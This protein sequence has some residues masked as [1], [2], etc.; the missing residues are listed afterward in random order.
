MDKWINNLLNIYHSIGSGS[1]LRVVQEIQNLLAEIRSSSQK[2]DDWNKNYHKNFILFL[3]SYN[4]TVNIVSEVF[5]H[6]KSESDIW[7]TLSSNEPII[8]LETNQ[9]SSLTNVNEFYTPTS[10]KLLFSSS[11]FDIKN[12]Q[13]VLF[14]LNNYCDYML[15]YKDKSKKSK[16]ALNLIKDIV[17]QLKGINE[18]SELIK[19]NQ[20]A[21]SSLETELEEKGKNLVITERNLKR[22]V[23]EIHNL[24]EISN[25]LYAILNLKQLIN[26]ALLIIV[27]QV[28][29]QKAFAFL[30]DTNN[31]KY[32]NRFTKGIDQVELSDLEIAV[33]HPL[34]SYF[35]NRPK[36]VLVEDLI[37]DTS[38]KP[39]F[40]SLFENQIEI[41]API[42]YGDR[43]Q[44]IVGCGTLLSDQKFSSNEM[45]I[46]NILINIISISVSNAQTYEDVKNLSLTDSMTNLNNYRHFEERLKEEITR[47]I[48]NK[49]TVSLL[50]LDLDHFKNYN[51]TLGHQ[52]GDEALRNVG[53]ILK[54]AV[55]EE[56]IVNR[57]GGEEFCIILPG[58][59]KNVI[60]VLGERIRKKIEE[61]PFYKENVQ[62]GGRVTVSLG[63]SSFPSDAD[64]FE[65]LVYNA[66]QALYKSKNS[67]RNRLTVFDTK[68]TSK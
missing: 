32:S 53:F 13:S 3:E 34:V 67:G 19:K 65:D 15:I 1:N 24:L 60:P 45:D 14:Q 40:N 26:S 25:E 18:D 63:G 58:I 66:D 46:F 30:Y 55:R 7:Y 39:V 29:C 6:F 52:A 17:N 12:S 31:R 47:G 68:L 10:A 28:G 44:G 43:I 2:G 42:I 59:E 21:I 62:P 37:K 27:G 33:D 16:K 22:R 5:Y 8:V 48:R 57:Y 50:M 61:Y 11:K 56:D 64:N 38:L 49:T 36:P 54:N 23:Y 9:I 41:I 20:K 4:K 35:E 51:D